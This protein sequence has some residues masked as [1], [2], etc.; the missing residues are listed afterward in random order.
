MA[1]RRRE[2]ATR[3]TTE[4][5]YRDPWRE[6]TVDRVVFFGR[7]Q[8]V[9]LG[10]IDLR[11]PGWWEAMIGLTNTQRWKA[12]TEAL[13]NAVNMPRYRIS[14]IAGMR[15]RVL[16][17]RWRWLGFAPA[18]TMPDASAWKGAMIY[19]GG[20]CH[21]LIAD[22]RRY[23]D[24]VAVGREITVT[25]PVPACPAMRLVETYHRP[26]ARRRLFLADVAI[27]TAVQA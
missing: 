1:K 14:E 18:R 7:S 13:L 2:A 20:S 6:L 21:G 3:S 8:G 22:D 23:E 15:V 24:Y 17:D 9:A 27:Q 11:S 12:Q 25:S 10:I 19:S 16:H 4:S 26:D 5:V